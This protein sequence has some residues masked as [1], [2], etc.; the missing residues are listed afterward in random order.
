MC[1]VD[2][3]FCSRA[4][5]RV[6]V[7]VAPKVTN[8][9]KEFDSVSLPCIFLCIWVDGRERKACPCCAGAFHRPKTVARALGRIRTNARTH[10]LPRACPQVAQSLGIQDF[11][12]IDKIRG[13]LVSRQ[14]KE[15]EKKVRC[16]PPTVPHW[17]RSHAMLYV[18]DSMV[19]RSVLPEPNGSVE[20]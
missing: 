18:L 2:C 19:G 8:S 15:A 1:F 4:P 14:E 17:P 16:A 6:V 11:D 12:V 3:C 10:L 5:L 13:Q 20:E 7:Q 9:K